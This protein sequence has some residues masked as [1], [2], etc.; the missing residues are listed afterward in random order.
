VQR[1]TIDRRVQERDSGIG[2]GVRM[3]HYPA[4]MYQG[5]CFYEVGCQKCS[6]GGYWQIYTDTKRMLARC[7]CGNVSEIPRTKFQ[8][9]PN[10]LPKVKAKAK[11]KPKAKPGVKKNATK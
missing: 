11:A 3:R 1:R 4:I 7:E 6:K 2:G 10:D 5:K 8:S 9:K